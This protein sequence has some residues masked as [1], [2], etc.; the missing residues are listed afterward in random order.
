MSRV[1]VVFAHPNLRASRIHTRLL[2]AVREVEGVTL[3][4]LYE[5]YPEFDVD[6]AA[7]QE[8]LLEHDVVVWQHPLFWY[9]V[10]P[11]LKQWIDLVLTHGWAYGSHG[12]A[13]EGKPLLSVISAGAPREA[14]APGGYNRFSLRPLLA[15]LEQTARLCG[16]R[17]LPPW[18]VFGSHRARAPEL[19][20]IAPAYEAIHRWLVAG[21]HERPDLDSR[22]FLDPADPGLDIRGPGVGVR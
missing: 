3:R 1:L 18:A 8:L 15:P 5:R 10:P 22:E 14:Y 2:E 4:D 13:L 9:S 20:R 21:G 17:Y 12:T 7:E 19:D 16:M 11:L 6:V